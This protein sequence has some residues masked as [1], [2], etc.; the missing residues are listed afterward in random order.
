MQQMQDLEAEALAEQQM[1]PPP[2]PLY[3]GGDYPEHPINTNLRSGRDGSLS[4]ID[5]M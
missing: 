4:K 5:E 3:T 1:I 2:L